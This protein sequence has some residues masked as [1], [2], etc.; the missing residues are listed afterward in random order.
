MWI[1][2]CDNSNLF[3][4]EER[5]HVGRNDNRKLKHVLSTP[6]LFSM[7]RSQFRFVM[8]MSVST[9]SSFCINISANFQ[10][11]SLSQVSV[12]LQTVKN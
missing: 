6:E 2:M 11:V 10:P 9:S 8:F 5:R 4:A 1:D 7:V 12:L 3:I